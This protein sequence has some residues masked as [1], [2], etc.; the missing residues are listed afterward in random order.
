MN[1]KY[2]AV[3]T[4]SRART[5][6]VL[7]SFPKYKSPTQARRPIPDILRSWPNPGLWDNLEC[8]G[9]GWWIEEA[10]HGG[11]LYLVSD[12]SYQRD[13][14]PE[15]CSCGEKASGKKLMCTWVER[16][17]A[18]SNY[19]GEILGALGYTLVMKAVLGKD[20]DPSTH[21]R[22]L[23]KGLAFCDNMGV[24]NHG[25]AP[26][27]PLSEKQVQADVLGHMKYL[28]RHLSAWLKFAHVRG[29]IDRVLSAINRNFQQN[30]QVACDK[31]ATSAL[32]K[33]VADDSGYITTLFPF[34]RVIMLCGNTRVTASATDAIYEWTSRETARAL[35]DE[36]GI[37]PAEY[38]DL[39]Y[40]KGLEKTMTTRFNTSFASFYT[41]H[42]I[43]CCG[44]RH[45]LHNIDS[46]VPNVCP[47]CG[48]EDETTAH[49]LLCPDK[50]RTIMYK[51]SVSKFISWM[52]TADTS[53]LIIE[54]VGEYLKARNTKTMS[55]VYEGP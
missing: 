36:K 27:K 40:W 5:V 45:H 46:S 10:L 37:V 23:P 47:C 19:R 33:V 6:A 13:V 30:L 55:E 25:D 16:S 35:Y 1:H 28:L 39:I 54:M 52:K 41:K 14:D 22:S 29:H 49:L 48:C 7:S 9:D 3:K 17:P 21:F 2:A 42:I 44:V 51:K 20:R 50:D 43:Q 53:P 12:G 24:C 18:A 34:E 11:S 8:D 15:V 4:N 32:T 26:N 38:F 31:K